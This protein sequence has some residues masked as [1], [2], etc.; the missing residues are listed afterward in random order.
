MDLIGMKKK[1]FAILDIKPN[2]F[3]SDYI[4]VTINQMQI[5]IFRGSGR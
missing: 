5:G 2:N 4:Y 3:K 1:S